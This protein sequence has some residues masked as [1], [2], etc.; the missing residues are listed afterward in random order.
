MKQAGSM[1][2]LGS[3]LSLL[4]SA[5]CRPHVRFPPLSLASF[6]LPAA[7]RHAV[8]RPVN[9]GAIKLFGHWTW[10]LWCWS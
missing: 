5:A 10:L 8:V 7:P 4:G 9:V 2:K 6:A 1:G 3:F